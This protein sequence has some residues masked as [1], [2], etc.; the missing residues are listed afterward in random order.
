MTNS[1]FKNSS[2]WK[3]IGEVTAQDGKMTLYVYKSVQF[4][5]NSVLSPRKKIEKS[6]KFYD[7]FLKLYLNPGTHL[8]Y[9]GF[10]MSKF[11]ERNQNY[12][13]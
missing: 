9:P 11:Q 1:T 6:S 2:I 10:F 7:D 13:I 5:A 4:T 12:E 8:S 3:N